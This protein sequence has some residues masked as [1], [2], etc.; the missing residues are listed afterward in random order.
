M[1]PPHF[2]SY[3]LS[4]IGVDEQFGERFYELGFPGDETKSLYVGP[5]VFRI[6]QFHAFDP[7][8]HHSITVEGEAAFKDHRDPRGH[9]PWHL[10]RLDDRID[11]SSSHER[12]TEG[13]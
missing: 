8:I 2:L 11:A 1:W 6:G 3:E 5:E 12:E 13:A 4:L 10:R 7:S 9:V